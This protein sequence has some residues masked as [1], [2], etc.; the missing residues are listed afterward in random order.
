[1]ESSVVNAIIAA[2]VSLVVVLITLFGTRV[3]ERKK[4]RDAIRN[5]EIQNRLSALH[6]SIQILQKLKNELR[7]LVGELQ[8]SININDIQAK[9]KVEDTLTAV[10]DLTDNFDDV[11][12]TGLSSLNESEGSLLHDMKHQFAHI[13]Q[14]LNHII[15][16]LPK[17]RDNVNEDIERLKEIRDTLTTFQNKYKAMRAKI[18]RSEKL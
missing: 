7:Y 5:Q 3:S 9:T 2:V 12:A 13:T 15:Y 4:L 6:S 16:D 8:V 11:Y 17:G 1:M 18:I 10:R 14:S